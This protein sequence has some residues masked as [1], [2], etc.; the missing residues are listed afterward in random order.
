MSDALVST[1]AAP[2]AAVPAPLTFAELIS[3]VRDDFRRAFTALVGFEVIFKLAVGFLLVP[4]LVALLFA[5]VRWSGRTA[6][7][8]EDIVRFVFS[9][10]GV[11]YGFL[12]GLKGLG[13]T[14]LEHAGAIAIVALKRS[15]HWHGL[16]H[17]MLA[18]ASRILAVLRL[19]A[20]VLAIAAVVL[21]PF[22][23]LAALTGYGL[24]GAQDINF[25]LAERPA[26]FYLACVIGGLLLGGAMALAAFLYVRWSLALCIV[27]LEKQA[28]LAALKL[29]AERTSGI[30]WRIAAVLL[31]WQF[32]GL[33]LQVLVLGAF[34]LLGALVLQG[35][36]HSPRVVLP[37][38]LLL[39]A[40]HAVVAA[41]V[42]A[43][44]VVVHC[45]LLLRL[46]VQRGLRL[47][48]LQAD[49]WADNLGPA[50][51]AQP[52]RLLRRME[53]GLAGA[54]M[55][56]AVALLA[57]TTT[58][59][60]QKDVEVTAHRGNSRA[61][62]ENSLAAI[63]K[64]IEVGA[65][66]AEIDV[67]LSKD[68]QIVLNHDRDLARVYG[69]R[70][71]VGALGLDELKRL[72]PRPRFAWGLEDERIATLREVLDLAGNPR[73]PIKVNIELKFYGKDRRL[74]KKV[75]DLIREY[76]FEDRCL[77]ASLDYRG[78][79]E[80]RAHN[81]GLKTA[82]IITAA[83]GDITRLDVDCLEINK[84]LATDDLLGKAHRLGKKVLVWTVDSRKEM[85]RFLDRGVD[86]IITNDPALLV[87]LRKE[88]DDL[89][90]SQRLLLACRHLLD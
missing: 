38:V 73:N 72:K 31:G 37:T 1:P 33:L 23:A 87:E 57:L 62:T 76:H 83:V 85:R 35:A 89:A 45:L 16:R 5:L 8:N 6:L 74:A 90:D 26:N 12:L 77:V 39:L 51:T 10:W 18:L 20:L 14:L 30:R 34:R 24:L 53:W 36:S 71:A 60:L 52:R 54:A 32:V 61:A 47:G 19:T 64:A 65:D 80:A 41:A 2:A 70:R 28:P 56:G 44:V 7:T 3:G 40:L 13:I 82:A 4:S 63:Q 78:L 27:L 15:G 88:R 75:A 49:H 79:L 81:K 67:Q 11:L 9:P 43:L 58:F 59:N 69:D 17:A 22:A 29:S 84:E 48:L 42:S 25:Y 86:S 68:G 21:A 46:Y 55:G 50:P 66:W